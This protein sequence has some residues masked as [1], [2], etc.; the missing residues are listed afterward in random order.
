MG[1]RNHSIITVITIILWFPAFSYGQEQPLLDENCTINILNRTIQVQNDGGWALPNIPANMG[2]IR[3]RATCIRDGKTI[4][5]QSDYFTVGP[6]GITEVGE[7]L[8]EKTDP[9]PS[10]LTFIPPESTTLDNTGTTLALRVMATYPDGSTKDVTNFESGINYSST[11]PAIASVNPDGVITA[12]DVGSVLVTARKDGAVAVKQI[13]ITVSGDSD[14]DGLPND[15]EIA[16]GLN[17]QDPV[18]AFEDKD[19]DALTVLQEFQLGTNPQRKDTDGDSLSDGDEINGVR[20]GNEIFTSDPFLLD[21]D[22]DGLSDGVEVTVG[23]NPSD[24]ADSD[25]SSALIALE[26]L[27]KNP[28]IT[29]NTIFT[30]S[31]IQLQVIGHL[32]NGEQLDLTSTNLGTTY[33]SNQ[34]SIASFGVDDG[35]IFAGQS[36]V[37]D[38]LVTNGNHEATVHVTVTSF[39]PT[40][41]SY[42][43][44]PGTPKNVEVSAGY[45]YVVAG[46]AGMQIV[47]VS[48][49]S[50]PFLA[51]SIN[52][53]GSAE[54]ILL[55]N[56]HAY[57]ADG[58]S[59][60]QVIDITNPLSP[61]LVG[62]LATNGLANGMA[63]DNKTLYL[64][65][66]NT[67]LA[68]NLTDPVSPFISGALSNLGE[69]TGLDV[70]N[71][72]MVAVGGNSLFVIDASIPAEMVLQNTL[73]INEAKDAVFDGRY[74]HV[75]AYTNGYQVYDLN[76]PIAPVS[77]GSIR[78]FFPLDLALQDGLVFFAE[79]LFVSAIPY[80]NITDSTT[81]LFQGVIDLSQFGDYDGNGIDVFQNNIYMT[82]HSGRL[83][84]AQYRFLEDNG[85]TPPLVNWISPQ[86]NITWIEGEVEGAQHFS[87]QTEASDDV[88]VA[89]VNF[90][91]NGVVTQTDIAAP[92]EFDYTFPEGLTGVTLETQAIDLSGNIGESLPLVIQ[93]IPDQ[94]TTAE[95][96][97]VDIAGIPV[98]GAEVSCSG[99]TG[100]TRIDGTFSI[101]QVSS[102][103]EQIQCESVYKN[104]YGFALN[105]VSPPIP[106]V[107]NGITDLGQFTSPTANWITPSTNAPWV[108]GERESITLE[109]Q[110]TE[111][112]S[113]TST[114]FLIDGKIQH[115][116][117]EPP[118][119]YAYSIP[120]GKASITLGALITDGNNHV[121]ETPFLAIK[122]IS[123]PGT[124]VGGQ[125]VDAANSP[126]IG[127]HVVCQGVSGLTQN[128]GY[129]T[130]SGVATISEDIQCTATYT[131]PYGVILTAVSPAIPPVRDGVT[132]V[133]TFSPA[134]AVPTAAW[135][136]PTENTIWVA[137][138][139]VLLQIA[140]T[141]DV[142]VA[143]VS[144]LVDGEVL[145]IDQQAPFEYSHTVMAHT[146]TVTVEALVKDAGNQIGKPPSQSIPVVPDPKTRVEGKVVDAMGNPVHEAVVT[147]L[148]IS[149]FTNQEGLFSMPEV[150]TIHGDIQCQS[151]YISPYDK[152][153]TA[154]SPAVTPV[155]QGVTFVGTFTPSVS[156]PRITWK[157]PVGSTSWIAGEQVIIEV[158]VTADVFIKS[159]ILMVNGIKMDSQ[160]IA[161]YQFEYTVPTSVNEITLHVTATD[162]ANNTGQSEFLK[163]Q[164]APDPGTTIIGTVLNASQIP[165]NGAQ[166][167]CQGKTG[168]S[169]ANGN[170]SIAGVSS[171]SESIQC[172]AMYS[173]TDGVITNQS[174]EFA[175]NR[176]GI[177][178]IG[179]ISSPGTT[180]EGKVL[181][182]AGIP[183][184]G[185]VVSCFEVRTKTKADGSFSIG[186]SLDASQIQC[187]T[188]YTDQDGVR[189]TIESASIE[190]VR[191]GITELGVLTVPDPGTVVQGKVVDATGRPVQGAQV[192]CA[193][194]SGTTSDIG[195]FSIPGAST[196]AG[197]IQCSAS[198]LSPYG[199]ALTAQSNSLVPVRDSVTDAGTFTPPAT[200]PTVSW[201]GP[202]S[203]EAL[204]EGDPVSLQVDATADIFI[205]SVT[206]SLDGVTLA[207]DDTYPYQ[208]TA[209]IPP[210][211][212]S[213]TFQV[214]AVDLSG[215]AGVSSYTISVIPDPGTTVVGKV[216]DTLNNPVS[217]STVSCLDR[218]GQTTSNG[219]F[220]IAN[221]STTSGKIQCS[222]A[223]NSPYGKLLTALSASVLP[224]RNGIT[225]MGTFS[226]PVSPPVVT[227][228][229]VE[230]NVSWVEG[231]TIMFQVQ[232]T[233]DVEVD[234]VNLSVNGKLIATDNSFPF[235]FTYQFPSVTNTTDIIFTA[236]ATDK[237]NNTGTSTRLSVSVNPDPG[238]TIKGKIVDAQSNPWA[239]I[240]VACLGMTG[241]TAETGRFFIPGVPTTAGAFQCHFTFNNS[242]GPDLTT[243]REV[244]PKR[245]DTVDLGN[246]SLIDPGTTVQGKVTNSIGNGL[247][248]VTVT[249]LGISRTTTAD[250][251][252]S[253]PNVPSIAGNFYC[254]ASF[255]NGASA[256][257]SSIV[258]PVR[259][260]TVN[261]GNIIRPS[262]PPGITWTAPTASSVLIQGDTASLQVSVN[263]EVSVKFVNF[264]VNGQVF[265]SD[266]TSPYQAEYVI[267]ALNLLSFRAYV[268]DNAGKSAQAN[269]TINVIPDPKTTVTG[270]ILDD[271]GKPLA[272][273]NVDCFGQS[274][275][276][277]YDGTFSV[278]GVPTTRGD[279]SCQLSYVHDG[280]NH[281]DSLPSIAPNRGGEVQLGTRNLSTRIGFR[282][283]AA[284][285]EHT[286]AVLEGRNLL[287]WGKGNQGQIGNG[288]TEDIRTPVAVPGINNAAQVSLGE[289]HSCVLLNNGSLKCWG[290]G[291]E[292][293]LGN[294][295]TNS[296][297][298]PVDVSGIANATHIALGWKHSCAIISGGTVRCWG[299]GSYGKLGNGS[300]SN[301]SNP[302]IVSGLSNVTQLS[303][304]F[305]HS[306]ALIGNGSV[307]CWGRGNW[308][309]LGGSDFTDR[310]TPST[311]L[312]VSNI[313]QIAVGGPHTCALSSSG[314]IKCW[315]NNH[316]G[317]LGNGEFHLATRVAASVSG[318]S[319]AIQ[320][321]VGE[322]HSC[323]LLNNGTMKCWGLG[324][325]GQLGNRISVETQATPVVATDISNV[326]QIIAGGAYTCALLQN[327]D[328]MGWGWA[329][330]GQ[331][332]I[333]DSSTRFTPAAVQW[334]K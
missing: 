293:Q 305:D 78:E 200:L 226:P 155:R 32:I 40:P 230:N 63:L 257:Q 270:R 185:R 7:I 131:N 58:N 228:N 127:A 299:E 324:R 278:T 157:H 116:D 22:G 225:A 124:M 264:M 188:S 181:D 192:T 199:K 38:I 180:V 16:N 84:I 17:P 137:E 323:A 256:A 10:S 236:S 285:R 13:T 183:V 46:E 101:P 260:G 2:R 289:D 215:R 262:L 25:F 316:Y 41:L 320:I 222:G 318:I 172:E 310:H 34:P 62:S 115:A 189:H 240:Q 267:P 184:V 35:R 102:T 125:V 254:Q 231:E 145:H 111:N 103:I 142:S 94:G 83:Y 221:V 212:S 150:P 162:L 234:S 321:D 169:D 144:F 258:T 23:T 201:I 242:S 119:Q 163:I 81:P 229:V 3:A 239:D 243:S 107:R 295:S 4:T 85:T 273:G 206:F 161:P 64:A 322:F 274:G 126:V 122:M 98:I 148:G 315:G 224:V 45:A 301:Q 12:I 151:A 330:S 223:Y 303:L 247:S 39:S 147:C 76:D 42:I 37:A 24:A 195:T 179:E 29:F 36:G 27:P 306:C 156:A 153:L 187:Q 218:T 171:I 105:A 281:T 219:T 167:T 314:S 70:K 114:R 216:V 205:A 143:S 95:G 208:L 141:A 134:A 44:L 178:E 138:D 235:Q 331:L 69:L 6:N 263:A 190:Q 139:T 130:I 15:Y 211:K 252:F 241:K 77:I 271:M 108:I 328:I 334:Q 88:Y 82:S 202:K 168:I 300:T 152:T 191:D 287:C 75:A 160:D 198:Y 210:G 47:D 121:G 79:E 28:I 74:V 106:P 154:H 132:D 67:L 73:E 123:D 158:D 159:L 332:G 166:I 99:I 253:I 291:S 19:R 298:T 96:K 214:S 279:I 92:Y 284:G 68:I 90:L 110:P 238:T 104:R 237:A 26:I 87:I 280:S 294:G 333:L 43:E 207:T 11:N 65:T 327:R 203:N 251:I 5:G 196:T 14:K 129:F 51:T 136:Y 232:A 244:T 282:S 217:G 176:N 246:I 50:T 292:G 86:S 9:I 140:A 164:I 261:A 97:I 319:N 174:L 286:C 72:Q 21:S 149:M 296:I 249:C 120:A 325:D 146:G 220:S 329:Y 165:V 304:G 112:Q 245:G 227:I 48:N 59:G 100:T 31:S 275:S 297:T 49:P 302:V 128:S 60:L 133:G 55:H 209:I 312:G 307:Q 283:I 91:V 266:T 109:I 20:V 177:T 93:I 173:T 277:S 248:N 311:V 117:N 250:G 89:V 194:V 326:V 197:N 170:F 182:V 276:T 33:K 233:A 265:H 193:D 52:T 290:R 56:K 57:V 308:G 255:D 18:D 30:E 175:P 313:S 213:L 309:Q 113:F 204:V 61:L 54:D 135:L 1:E 8:F 186:L 53:P 80:V 259:N 269:L 71:G 268:E 272:G 118:F 317:E 66:G 288:S